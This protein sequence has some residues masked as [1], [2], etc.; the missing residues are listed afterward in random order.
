M[1]V[2]DELVW[3]TLV[4]GTHARLMYS[5]IRMARNEVRP[6]N[7]DGA[8]FITEDQFVGTT[9]ARSALKVA[10]NAGAWRAISEL[11]GFGLLSP[12]GPQT[13]R[14]TFGIRKSKGDLKKQAQALVLKHFSLDV[15]HDVAESVLIAVHA[16]VRRLDRPGAL[17]W[18]VN[19]EKHV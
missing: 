6:S 8:M 4:D 13:W 17:A 10:R 3:W 9:N 2:A 12:V 7:F 18:A 1:F 16:Q 19:G 15:G 5:A 14:K 11:F